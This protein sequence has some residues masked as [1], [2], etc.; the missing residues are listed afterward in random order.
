MTLPLI[1]ARWVLLAKLVDFCLM[2][3]LLFK[4]DLAA[5]QKCMLC[6]FFDQ[7]VQTRCF[8]R[9]LLHAVCS[10]TCDLCIH[11]TYMHFFC[12][13]TAFCWLYVC[14][15]LEGMFPAKS[16]HECCKMALIEL[17]E[18]FDT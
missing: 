9:S 12:T 11:C 18:T 6:M 14:H 2:Q 1:L 17:T 5:E 8:S 10:H 4:H 15:S 16:V 13:K 7:N 3:Q